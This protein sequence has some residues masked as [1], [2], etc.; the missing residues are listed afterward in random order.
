MGINRQ[1]DRNGHIAIGDSR[2]AQCEGIRVVEHGADT[3][4]EAA[5]STGDSILGEFARPRAGRPD[6]HEANV[7]R[8]EPAVRKSA[9]D[10]SGRLKVGLFM[11]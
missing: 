4:S 11:R 1:R 2:G 9:A 6:G 5:Q 8:L 7:A 3:G 10:G